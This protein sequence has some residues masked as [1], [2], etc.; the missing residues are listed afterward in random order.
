MSEPDATQHT[1]S[2]GSPSAL[3]ALAGNDRNLAVL[4]EALEEKGARQNTDVL[5]V[6]DHGF[7]TVE[8]TVDVAALLQAGGIQR[9]EKAG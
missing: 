2:P 7:S 4:L 9:V 8:Q 1:N 6:S 5:V 3:Q